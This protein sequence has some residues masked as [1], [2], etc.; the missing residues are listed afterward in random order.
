MPRDAAALLQLI[1]MAQQ[2]QMASRTSAT[3]HSLNKFLPQP[4]LL[5][6]LLATTC[7]HSHHLHALAPSAA[8]C[9]LCW[10]EHLLLL[11]L[12]ILYQGGGCW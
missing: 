6:Q 11:L 1:A 8:S 2:L 4:L 12:Q 7:C 3:C 9:S 10:P 5:K